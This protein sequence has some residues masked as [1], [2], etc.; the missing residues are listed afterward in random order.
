[1]TAWGG[2]LTAVLCYHDLCR[3]GK[4]GS[5]LKVDVERFERQI[6]ALKKIGAFI[7]P[8]ALLEH[9]PLTRVGL[10]LLLTF[11]DGF[12]N[13]FRLG[14][15]VLQRH[16]VPA[17]FFISTGHME[18]GEP[19]W[20]DRLIR[21]IQHYRLAGLDLR[22]LGLGV[23]SFSSADGASRWNGIQRLLED[24]KKY[25]ERQDGQLVDRILS[26][27]RRDEHHS[28][29]FY[30]DDRPLSRDE[31]LTMQRSGLCCFGSHG[32]RHRIL[33]KLGD[34]SLW[35]ELQ[36]SRNILEGLLGE[37]IAHI[38]YPNGNIDSRV[39]EACRLAGY[40]FGYTVVPG[41]VSTENDHYHIPRIMVSGFDTT[42]SLLLNLAR[43]LLLSGP[44]ST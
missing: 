38:S 30:E 15:P 35:E 18:S 2:R 16:G 9:A 4:S 39:I 3:P 43:G 12:V 34:N 19:F 6:V 20:F 40:R 27:L 44:K 13:N 1:M 26:V 28:N 21:P 29:S 42:P 5:W 37:P 33:T 22:R 31:I 11:D 23:Y 41:R 17:L 24:V 7:R 25:D 10:N 14:L 32:H 36:Q 8:D